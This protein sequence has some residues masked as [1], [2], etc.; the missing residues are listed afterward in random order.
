MV[1][2]RHELW[3]YGGHLSMKLDGK[4]KVEM[5][6]HTGHGKGLI[7]WTFDTRVIL[8]ICLRCQVSALYRGCWGNCVL[9]L[10]IQRE[11]L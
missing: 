6:T 4:A 2:R 10:C 7:E 11:G 3:E 1:S 8:P 9:E 5:G